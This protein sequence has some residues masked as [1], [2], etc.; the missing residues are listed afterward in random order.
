VFEG[1]VSLCCCRCGVFVGCAFPIFIVVAAHGLARRT[2][3]NSS[4]AHAKLHELH[5]SKSTTRRRQR[6][7]RQPPDRTT[8]PTATMGRMH[9]KGKGISASAI[10]YSRTPPAWLKTTPEQVVDQIGKLAKKGATPS[11]SKYTRAERS[12]KFR[13]TSHTN[14]NSR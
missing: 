8:P 13:R 5:V 1:V 2:N 4:R 11:Q 12:T 6:T 10:P 7:D 14:G 9:S 3:P